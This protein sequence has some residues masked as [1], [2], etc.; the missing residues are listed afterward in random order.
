MC[1]HGA[2]GTICDDEWDSNDARVACKQLGY[3][4]KAFHC[5]KIKVKNEVVH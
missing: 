2:W 1:Y 3:R 5:Y 4:Y